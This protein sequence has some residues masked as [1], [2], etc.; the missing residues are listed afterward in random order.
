MAVA[1][2]MAVKSPPEKF[3]GWL[4]ALVSGRNS[5]RSAG[6]AVAG[7]ERWRGGNGVVVVIVLVYWMQSDAS[8]W[9]DA[10]SSLRC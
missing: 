8:S 5:G 1:V 6:G 2:V 7:M 3:S 9:N 10:S 4:A